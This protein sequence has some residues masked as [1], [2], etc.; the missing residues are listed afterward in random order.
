MFRASLV[1]GVSGLREYPGKGNQDRR[2]KGKVSILMGG[3]GFR[4]EGGLDLAS[5]QN[6]TRDAQK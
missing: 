6:D 3:M 2:G 1:Y 4:G 5:E